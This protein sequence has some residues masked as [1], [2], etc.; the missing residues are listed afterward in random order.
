MENGGQPRFAAGF[1]VGARTDDDARHRQ[2]AQGAAQRIAHALSRQ[3]LVVFGAHARVHLIDS[4][5]TQQRLGGGDESD[6]ESADDHMVIGKEGRDSRRRRPY[7]RRPDVVRHVDVFDIVQ[8][9][10]G[11]GDH[12]D[13]D[14]DQRRRDH[15][16]HFG[17]K[18][19]PGEDR[20]DRQRADFTGGQM[21]VP[22][23]DGLHDGAGNTHEVLD[24]RTDRLAIQ[25]H[26]ELGGEDQDADAGEHAVND[27]RRDRAKP[28]AELHHAGQHL[29]ETGKE[30]DCAKHFDAEILDQ[31]IDEN[32]QTRS[33]A[34]D[35]Q[36]RAGNGADN[37]AADD[38]GYDAR[39]RRQTG[40]Q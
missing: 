37:D 17:C 20:C 6:G 3:F 36:G 40:S 32:R 1:H 7:D 19:R 38:P 30:H 11:S 27:G 18:R 34:R 29:D 35:L 12:A 26:V 16:E 10:D 14:A 15:L 21:R 13:D 22:C 39:R 23:A 25:H 4:G 31:L 9:E 2:N 28:L 33:R 5:C 24:T 8:I